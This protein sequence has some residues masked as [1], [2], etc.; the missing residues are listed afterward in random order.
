MTRIALA[1]VDAPSPIGPLLLASDGRC[2]VALDF[3]APEDRLLRLLR[4]RFGTGVVLAEAED[5][6]GFA[7]A[8]G[9]YLAGRLDALDA[10]PADGGGSSFQRRVWAA[11]RAI[12][13]GETRS[14]GAVA[15]GIGRPGA[16]RAV[17]LANGSNPVNLVVPCHRVIGGT[18]TLTGY[19][20]G[21]DRKRWLLDH[22]SR[23]AGGGLPLFARDALHV[24]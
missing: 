1:R 23:W 4:A 14:Y 21:I 24:P 10:L 20:G 17:G 18:G 13:P 16:A 22:E 7:A 3:G 6:Q 11:L 19:G 9:A 2:L 15:S 8:L 12:P 5:P